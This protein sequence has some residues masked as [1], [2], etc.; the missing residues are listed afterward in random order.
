MLG[1]KLQQLQR[2]ME[3]KERATHNGEGDH[4]HQ[5]S[6]QKQR[7]DGQRQVVFGQVDRKYG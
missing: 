2:G 4:D 3:K 7:E 5:P 6:S 1:Y